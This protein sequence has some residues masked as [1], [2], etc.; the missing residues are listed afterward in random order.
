MVLMVLALGSLGQNDEIQPLQNWAAEYA[1]PAF[2]MLPT[3]VMENDIVAVQCLILFRFIQQSFTY[4]SIYFMWLVKPAHMYNFI[5][6][7]SMKI[8]HLVHW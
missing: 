8:Q 7:A 3:V 4:P 1:Q 2:S 6:M 5:G